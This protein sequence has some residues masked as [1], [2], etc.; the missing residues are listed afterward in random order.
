MNV[1]IKRLMPTALM[2]SG[3]SLVLAANAETYLWTGGAGTTLLTTPGNWSL[4]DGSATAKAPGVG[5]TVVFENAETLS[6]TKGAVLRYLAYEFRN[7]NVSF[8]KGSG[9]YR[10]YGYG[11]G[12]ITASGEGRRYAF[13][14]PLE[15]LADQFTGEE[16]TFVVDVAS[17]SSVQ[18][19]DSGTLK[20]YAPAVF[21]K[22]GAGTFQCAQFCRCPRRSRCRDSRRVGC[23]SGDWIQVRAW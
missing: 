23:A 7:A 18:V 13:G 9:N 17:G 2:L 10:Q 16:K 14:Y 11:G 19:T 6:L 20:L 15:L 12:G 3:F 8:P 5:D 1:K 4:S 22:R 21:V